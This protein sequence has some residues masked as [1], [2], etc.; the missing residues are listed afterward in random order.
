MT[1][2]ST[3]STLVGRAGRAVAGGALGLALTAAVALPM[4]TPA[5][6]RAQ[7]AAPALWVVRDADSTLYLFGSVHVL[8]PDT[9]WSSARVDAA[10][11]SADEIWFEIPNMDDPSAGVAFIQQNGVSPDR[12][13]SS[14]LSADEMTRLD[15][16]A[17]GIGATGAQ[18]DPM[19]PWFAAI[20]LTI[21]QVVKAGY[22]PGSG[23]D[24]TL[25]ARARA[26]EKP[27]K[28]FETVDQQLG[29]M[30]GMSEA[31]QVGFL[32]Y[33]LEGVDE[34]DAVLGGMVEAWRAG[35]TDRLNA[36]IIDEWRRDYPALYE[37]LLTRR[38]AD[39][40]EQIEDRLE[41]SGVSFIVVGAGHLVGTESVQ[42]FLARKG[43]TATRVE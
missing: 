12:P 43:I 21:A 20:T 38:N 5:P 40:A 32:R 25:L 1:L 3:L 13:L 33:T 23:V 18:M 10:L 8:K 11:D 34:A 16:A 30:A 41:G 27:V 29:I 22:Q 14:L 4:L 26:A 17:R 9:Q 28:G 2:I 7:D 19:R 37:A 36:I 35:D 6:A 42:T 15:A 39:W 24:L 31:D